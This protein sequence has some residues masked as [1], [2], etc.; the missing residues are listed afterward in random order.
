MG[1]EPIWGCF[2][3]RRSVLTALTGFLNI[4]KTPLE[5]NFSSAHARDGTVKNVALRQ[6]T[7]G[8]VCLSISRRLHSGALQ[9]TKRLHLRQPALHAE[10]GRRREGQTRV[11][12]Y[13]ISPNIFNVSREL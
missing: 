3:P 4:T 12:W 8:T 13:L 9:R 5:K 1:E 11:I 2:Y 7:A 10:S 6:P